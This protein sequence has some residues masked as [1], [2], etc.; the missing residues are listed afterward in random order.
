MF[1]VG[2][3]SIML[4]G[5]SILIL[6][7]LPLASCGWFG[8]G[9]VTPGDGDGNGDE[10]GVEGEHDATD[11]RVDDSLIPDNDSTPFDALDTP[12]PCI[13]NEDC[14]DANVCTE[15]H[16][17][18]DLGCVYTFNTLP[19]DDGDPC[20]A[21]GVCA[22]GTCVQGPYQCE[23][24]TAE[25]CVDSHDCTEDTCDPM[26]YLCVYTPSAATDICRSPAGA[27]DAV[28]YCSG[29][30]PDC[31]ADL[32]LPAGEQGQPV[33][34]R[35]SG[36]SS[37]P[38]N[39]PDGSQDSEGDSLCSQTCMECLGGD[40]AYQGDG[41]DLFGQCLPSY[42]CDGTSACTNRAGSVVLAGISASSNVA[43]GLA[44]ARLEMTSRDGTPRVC[45]VIG[46][47]VPSRVACNAN[48]GCNEDASDATMDDCLDGSNSNCNSRYV[49]NIT[50][51]GTTF[52]ISDTA[53]VTCEFFC[54]NSAIDDWAIAYNSGSGWRNVAFGHCEH[55]G[56]NDGL[57]ENHTA[58]V[59]VD[60]V[61]GTHYARCIVGYG[62]AGAS[63]TC[64]TQLN[65]MSETDDLDFYVIAVGYKPS[66]SITS[67]PIAP[68]STP[69]W[70]RFYAT[71]DV[72]ASGT[73]ISYRILNSFDDSVLCT[74]SSVPPEGYDI[75]VCAAGAPS[76]KLSADLTTSSP[77]STPILYDWYVT[78]I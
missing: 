63:T 22:G 44:D 32:F 76:I 41:E 24:R 57:H 69:G 52:D 72:S 61:A 17:D 3:I 23:C 73:A 47:A 13:R 14:D 68:S 8:S 31:P 53:Q 49:M 45:N 74:A 58:A 60:D 50:V 28:E 37:A 5:A 25:D 15:D 51:N 65:N 64:G 26:T 7:F 54:W 38:V 67:V 39:V 55:G 2:M 20:T 9:P 10:E 48:T 40:C 6:L 4:R 34:R 1:D 66:G 71:E 18:A 11:A 46:A 29:A 62:T 35:C 16:C 43:V 42:H 21:P 56:Y 59:A 33:C 75:S 19:C 77:S 12:L 36:D 27:C 70:L 78:W 30:D